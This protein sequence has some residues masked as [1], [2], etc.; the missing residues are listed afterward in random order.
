MPFSHAT[1]EQIQKLFLQFYPDD[2]ALGS[3]SVPFTPGMAM[4][5]DRFPKIVTTVNRDKCDMV[6]PRKKALT[7]A[8]RYGRFPLPE[9]PQTDGPP[10]TSLA[11]DPVKASR[12]YGAR[13]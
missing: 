4:L 7:Q 9:F 13:K 3:R 6:R 11:L 2:P 10:L 8:W 12:A 1:A 5:F